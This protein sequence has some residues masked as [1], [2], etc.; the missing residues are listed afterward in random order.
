MAFIKVTIFGKEQNVRVCDYCRTRIPH[1]KYCS[2]ICH[3]AHQER[4]LTAADSLVAKLHEGKTDTGR[5]E[6]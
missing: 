3:R 4:I 5:G 1:G 2:G 6:T